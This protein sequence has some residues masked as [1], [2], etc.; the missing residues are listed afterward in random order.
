MVILSPYVA[1]VQISVAHPQLDK[2]EGTVG[3]VLQEC[4]TEQ[5]NPSQSGF[6]YWDI[7]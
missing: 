6:S 1:E 7:R 4:A 3:V 5:L 2:G